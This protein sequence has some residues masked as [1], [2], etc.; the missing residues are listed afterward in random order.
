MNED[1]PDEIIDAQVI[2]TDEATGPVIAAK[3]P[4]SGAR[5]CAH[6]R[7][8]AR[9]AG[10]F[11]A[12]D[13]AAVLSCGMANSASGVTVIT[14]AASGFG[15]EFARRLAAQGATL[16]L[17][18]VDR[19][20]LAETASLVQATRNQTFIVDVR[21][22]AAVAATAE[23]TR[24]TLGPVAHVI[25]SAGILRVGSAEQSGAEAARLM[26]DVNYMGSVNVALALLPQLQAAKGKSSLLFIASVAGLR[27][28]PELAGY[29]ASKFAVVGYSQALR[30]ELYGSGV[31][32][33]VLCPPAGDTPMFRNIE[34]K[35]AILKMSTV[36]TAEEIVDAALKGMARDEWLILVDAKSKVVR[37]VDGLLPG[38]VDRIVRIAK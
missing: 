19:A 23:A 26:M 24:S 34:N 18:D 25:N 9:S 1:R 15:R 2:L 7:S 35:P 28:F 27:G 17:W 22:A 6:G 20:G 14:G 30:E 32:V 10:G 37:R 36:C 33:Q 3:A 16:A 4:H 31:Q 21:D 12:P 11:E 29:C 5:K 38:L 8:F 13:E